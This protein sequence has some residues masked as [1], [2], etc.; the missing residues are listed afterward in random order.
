M[1]AK[2]GHLITLI[3]FAGGGFAFA[4]L[5]QTHLENG[6]GGPD[7]WWGGFMVGVALTYGF[8]ALVSKLA[9]KYNL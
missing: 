8:L 7:I 2:F 6:N 9:V 3:I 5:A 1:K 4:Q